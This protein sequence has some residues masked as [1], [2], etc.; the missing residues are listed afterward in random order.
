MTRDIL[1]GLRIR[2]RQR[3]CYVT[4]RLLKFQT[5]DRC[6]PACLF[7]HFI[8]IWPRIPAASHIILVFLNLESPYQ[9][10]G[11][12]PCCILLASA[13]TSSLLWI[14]LNQPPDQS[15]HPLQSS[16]LCEDL[17]RQG[18]AGAQPILLAVFFERCIP[19]LNML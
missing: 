8:C 12:L 16:R 13:F 6:S 10:L 19:A 17:Q 11:F 9:K 3:D 4:R 5:V 7:F 15:L 18:L 14:S 2:K 1:V